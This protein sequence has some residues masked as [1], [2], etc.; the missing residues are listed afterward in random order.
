MGVKLFPIL[1]LKLLKHIQMRIFKIQ[2]ILNKKMISASLKKSRSEKLRVAYLAIKDIFKYIIKK[3]INIEE[4]SK[5]FDRKSKDVIERVL[6]R[7]FYLYTHNIFRGRKLISI[8]ELNEQKEIN[9]Y[10]KR[11]KKKFKLSIDSYD[12]SIFYYKCGLK[13]LY[14]EI[15]DDLKGKDFID[16]GAYIGD[17]ALMFEKFYDPKKIYAF[18]P[19]PKNYTFLLKTIKMNN[20]KKIIP[21]NK[22][23]GEKEAILQLKSEGISSHISN[24]CDLN[25]NIVSIDNFVFKNNLTVGLIKL[26]IEGYELKALR[27]AIKT[28]IKF[29]PVLLI[30]IY[31]NGEEFFETVN[32][33]KEISSDYR[34]IIRKLESSFYFIESCLIA[35][36]EK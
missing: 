30:S 20:L 24:K 6:D 22:G 17:S 26:D 8:E 29:K 9:N 32:Y 11:L 1:I 36:S 14:P 33:I 31:H 12:S 27:G 2:T 23:L 34:C 16:G 21:I 4:F 10:L 19:E 3:E 35:W 25:V 28:I 18:E 15:I 7:V 13:Y 5:N